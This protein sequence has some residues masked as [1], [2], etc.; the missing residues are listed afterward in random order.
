[1]QM[2][3]HRLMQLSSAKQNKPVGIKGSFLITEGLHNEHKKLSNSEEY[4]YND[5]MWV[6]VKIPITSITPKPL[7]PL[8]KRNVCCNV[9]TYITTLLRY[10]L[11]GNICLVS[12][13]KQ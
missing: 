12:F 11:R 5:G 10:L 2:N 13:F 4:N 8:R 6:L 9:T 3:Q 1:M 7:I